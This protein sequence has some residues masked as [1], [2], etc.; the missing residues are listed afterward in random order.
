MRAT[1]HHPR[2]YDVEGEELRLRIWDGEKDIWYPITE[3]ELWNLS[4]DGFAALR[5]LRQRRQ[6][7]IS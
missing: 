7:P 4:E 5:R 6:Q 3:G 2:I 1:N